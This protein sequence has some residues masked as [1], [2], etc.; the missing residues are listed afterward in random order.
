MMLKSPSIA[1]LFP[2]LFWVL[3]APVLMFLKAVLLLVL[4]AI[5]GMEP[6][7]WCVEPACPASSGLC[8]V[9]K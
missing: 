5:L 9:I 2:T 1:I 8:C 4:L 7:A 6:R 3:F